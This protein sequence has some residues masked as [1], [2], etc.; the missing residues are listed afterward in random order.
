MKKST[1]LLLAAICVSFLTFSKTQAQFAMNTHSM[2]AT[3]EF[4]YLSESTAEPASKVNV[5]AEKN[6]TKSY[7][8][9]T[10]A[11]WFNLSDK[12]IM[13]RFYVD[14][15]LHRAFYTPKGQWAATVSSYDGSKL[16][17]AIS[18]NIKSAYYNSRIVF[19]EQIDLVGRK[20]VY[21]V[22]IHDEKSIRKLKVDSDD[23]QVLMEFEKN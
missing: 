14:N 10:A 8:N 22:E 12:T 4:R 6:F 9:A 23:I 21:V 3:G 1:V 19:V 11:E 15:I 20:P 18:E 2:S 7:Q 17:K 5:K 16:D 13:C